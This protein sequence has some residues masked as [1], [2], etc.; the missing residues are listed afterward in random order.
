MQNLL[1]STTAPFRSSQ[2]VRLVGI[3]ILTLLLLIPIRMID[4]L[5]YERQYRQQS[6]IDEV[7]SKWGKSQSIIGPE[8]IVP[9]TY[10]W[11]EIGVNGQTVSR[12]ETRQAFFLPEKLEVT[13]KIDSSILFRGIYTV[14]VY[15]L[16]LLVTG[17]FQPNLSELGIDPANVLWEHTQLSLGISDAHAI[18]QQTAVSWNGT[19]I[20]FLPGVNRLQGS[21]TGIHAPVSIDSAIPRYEF[22]FPLLLN[23]SMDLYFVPFGQETLVNLECNSGNP[24]FQG[25]WLP[26]QRTISDS[27]FSAKWVIPFLG[28]NYPQTWTSQ[29]DM[30][31]AIQ[32]SQFGVSLV[33]PINSYRMAERSVKYA[34]LFIFLPFTVIWLIEVLAGVRVH[35]IQYLLLGMALCLFYLLELSLM[36]HLGFFFAYI[37]AGIAIIG[38]AG[39]YSHAIFRRMSQTI[40]V[41]AVV[42]GLYAYLYILLT[43]GDYA[44][45]IGSLGLFAILAVVMFA[46]RHVDW[47]RMPMQTQNSDK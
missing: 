28:R 41:T 6:V 31:E 46:T 29:T 35:P 3:G 5:V 37:L 18:Q 13:G 47:Y 20:P 9:Y 10:R 44:L 27:H 25:N 43:N 16:N 15:K 26:I 42:G 1:D 12:S 33:D 11:N 21:A 7:S 2:I 14:P 17:A 22:N 32:S 19:S 8:L 38:M 23:G 30:Q 40:L 45:L 36:E 24:S 34:I 4:G 39:A